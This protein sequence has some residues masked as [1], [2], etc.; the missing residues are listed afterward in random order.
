MVECPNILHCC[1]ICGLPKRIHHA[2]DGDQDWHRCTE[3]RYAATLRQIS[4]LR[5]KCGSTDSNKP[6]IFGQSHVH[7][8][9]SYDSGRKVAYDAYTNSKQIR[10]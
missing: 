9:Y 4:H 2:V 8:A 3:Q 7:S 6:H 1:R 5:K 10:P